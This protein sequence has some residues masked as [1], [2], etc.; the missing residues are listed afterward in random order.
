MVRHLPRF[1]FRQ[2]LGGILIGIT[3]AHGP[4]VQAQDDRVADFSR[5][6][7]ER[8]AE[9]ISIFRTVCVENAFSP[10]RQ[11]EAIASTSAR[12]YPEHV[13][14]SGYWSGNIRVRPQNE[15][16]VG[17]SVYLSDAVVSDRDVSAA[18][19]SA[20]NL[21]SEPEP[22]SHLPRTYTWTI[23]NNTDD[24]I[25]SFHFSHGFHGIVTLSLSTWTGQ[26]QTRT[27]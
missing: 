3:L 26:T 18:L 25:I 12:F 7:A 4:A 13:V 27:E 21:R 19:A 15:G 16:T 8:L 24:L 17:C 1:E 10:E 22:V 20:L 2:A 11:V 14:E 23:R 9:A 5:V 6:Q